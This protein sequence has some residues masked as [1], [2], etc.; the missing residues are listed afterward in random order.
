MPLDTP[1]NTSAASP[2]PDRNETLRAMGKRAE[3]I[4]RFAGEDEGTSEEVAIHAGV[5]GSVTLDRPSVEEYSDDYRRWQP[6]DE[7]VV[8]IRM[9]QP[10]PRRIGGLAAE[11]VEAL[12]DILHRQRGPGHRRKHELGDDQC[13]NAAWAMLMSPGGDR[14]RFEP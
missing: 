8:T 13:I 14:I 9:L 3:V 12:A 5:V 11:R 1:V 10:T 4:L 7:T 2:F 6:G